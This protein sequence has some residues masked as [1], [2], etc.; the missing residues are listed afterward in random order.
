MQNNSTSHNN[1]LHVASYPSS[2]H[3]TVLLYVD[4]ADLDHVTNV[5][6]RVSQMFVFFVKIMFLLVRLYLFDHF[7]SR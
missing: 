7:L 1:S 3:V 5:Q 6:I 4:V 2:L